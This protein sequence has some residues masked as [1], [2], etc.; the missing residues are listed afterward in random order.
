MTRARLGTLVVATVLGVSATVLAADGGRPS[1]F[2][3]VPAPSDE[4]PP[5]EFPKTDAGALDKAALYRELMQR[6]QTPE[7]ME[8]WAKRV[9]EDSN[10]PGHRISPVFGSEETFFRQI[11]GTQ[12]SWG[13]L[14]RGFIRYRWL[15]ASLVL[16]LIGYIAVS[17]WRRWRRLERQF[18]ENR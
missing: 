8:R 10:E 3:T 7:A 18:L 1:A 16:A 15:F 2:P 17:N 12:S 6:D 13:V 9:R 5:P 11:H 14:Y 4:A